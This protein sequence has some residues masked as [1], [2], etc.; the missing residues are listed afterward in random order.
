MVE[1]GNPLTA[2]RNVVSNRAGLRS[3]A[4][5]F[6]TYAKKERKFSDFLTFFAGL[7]GMAGFGLFR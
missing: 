7:Y 3:A 2:A 6:R 4:T 5:A 1:N